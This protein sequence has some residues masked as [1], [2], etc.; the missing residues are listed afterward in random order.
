MKKIT[1][2]K[3]DQLIQKSKPA[4]SSIKQVGDDTCVI[5]NLKNGTRLEVKYNRES[6]NKTYYIKK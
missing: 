4:N 1:R 5:F 6:L 2:E 3:A